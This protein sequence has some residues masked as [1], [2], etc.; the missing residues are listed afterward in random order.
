M[1]K[2][3]VTIEVSTDG[4][5]VSTRKKKAK[6]KVKSILDFL[7]CFILQNKLRDLL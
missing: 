1:K 7:V 2:R 3:K 4:V 6:T 5:R